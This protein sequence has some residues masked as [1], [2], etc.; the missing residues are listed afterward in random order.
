MQTNM[1]FFDK[2]FHQDFVSEYSHSNYIDEIDNKKFFHMDCSGFVYWCL[3]QMGY[4]RA[5]VELRS[6]LKQNDFIKINRFFCKDFSFIYEHK[7]E[8]K[9]WDFLDKPVCGSIMIV[10]FPDGNGHCMFID[11][12]TEN[13]KNCIKLRVI[14]STR[15]PHLND[16]RPSDKTGIGIGEIEICKTNDGWLYNSNNPSLSTRKA[17][18]YFIFPKNKTI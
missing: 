11:E 4:K 6:F 18:I 2:L 17:E 8:L 16:T 14:D 7:K 10:V 1:D 12:I 3:A 5:L 13:N 9:Y 15:Y